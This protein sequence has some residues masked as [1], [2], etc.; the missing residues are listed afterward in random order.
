MDRLYYEEYYALEREHWWFRARSNILSVQLDRICDRVNG[1]SAILNVGAAVGASSEMLS[2]HG[3][4]TSVEYDHECCRFVRQHLSRQFIN[5]SITGLPFAS[6]TFDVVCAFDVIEHVHDDAIAV[7]ELIRVCRPGGAVLVTVPAFML[8]WSHHDDVNHHH[9]RYRLPALKKLFQRPG[10]LIFA[11]Y[12]NSALFPPIAG[13]RAISKM[14]PH[15]WIR[16]GA[17]SDFTLI[18]NRWLDR[19]CYRVLDS[20]NAWLRRGRTFPFGVSALVVWQKDLPPSER[21][22]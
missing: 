12:F 18:E 9:R 3:R 4:V 10:R 19:L 5:A 17:G 2:R 21:V 14:L 20:E 7:A 11:S 15:S 16:R 13:L 22:A 1:R 8:L 6:N